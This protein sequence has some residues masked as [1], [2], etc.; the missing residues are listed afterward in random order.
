MTFMQ[1]LLFFPKKHIPMLFI[2]IH[3]RELKHLPSRRLS[4]FTSLE[5]YEVPEYKEVMHTGY[6]EVFNMDIVSEL[7][8]LADKEYKAFFSKLVPNIDADTVIGVRTPELKALAKN[9]GDEK[10]DFI[11]ALPHKYY[12]E[13]NLHAFVINGI[14]DYDECIA[15]LEKFLPYIDNWATCDGLRPRCFAKNKDKLLEN[16]KVWL[17]SEHTYTVRFGIEML[18]THFLDGDFDAVYHRWVSK[19]KSDEYYI[20]MMIAWY[21]A[22][23]LC[24]K[25]EETVM[26][27]TE[28]K[29]SVWVHNKTVQ[30]AVES[31]RITK[32][33]KEYLKTL[34]RKQ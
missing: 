1:Y 10:Y 32:E 25:W 6:P 16:I 19:I 2:I 8:K 9:M 4:A 31:F 30:K 24:K 22:T 7:I 20:N 21:F 15:R 11:D 33:Q 28:N 34:R 14:G 3:K 29:L 18:M 5:L 17:N 13:N 27:L 26:Y 12:E 23:A